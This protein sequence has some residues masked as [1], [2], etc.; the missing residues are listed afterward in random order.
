MNTPKEF[1]Q[2]TEASQ[3]MI[4]GW[5]IAFGRLQKQIIFSIDERFYTVWGNMVQDVMSEYLV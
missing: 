5:N 4:T 2:N 1:Y 3:A